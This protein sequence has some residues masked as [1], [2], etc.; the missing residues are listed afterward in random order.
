MYSTTRYISK[1]EGNGVLAVSILNELTTPNSTVNNDI[2]INVFVSMGDDFEVFVPTEDFGYYTF[3]PQMSEPFVLEPQS[4]KPEVTPDS[5]ST[6]QDEPE[7]TEAV[8]IGPTISSL[9]K[10]N[11]VF[12]G[13]SIKSFRQMLKRYSLHTSYQP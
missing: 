2:T 10:I 12:T 13:E 1:E 7:H 6:Q 8:S 4:S 3:A 11:T 9:D 5:F